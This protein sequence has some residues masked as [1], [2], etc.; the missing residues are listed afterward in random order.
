MT[1]EQRRTGSKGT[2]VIRVDKYKQAD[3]KTNNAYTIK[4]HTYFM[5]SIV[6]IIIIRINKYAM[7][8]NLFKL[9]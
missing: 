7:C 1:R 8:S 6:L 9:Q 5:H 2:L 3:V 4:I